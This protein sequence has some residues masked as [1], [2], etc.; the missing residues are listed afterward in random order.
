MALVEIADAGDRA[1]RNR[2]REFV[3]GCGRTVLTHELRAESIEG[4]GFDHL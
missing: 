1:L 4:F 3:V 2:L